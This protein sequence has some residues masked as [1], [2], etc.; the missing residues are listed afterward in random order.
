MRTRLLKRRSIRA[1]ILSKGGA[2]P[3]SL[4]SLFHEMQSDLSSACG[5]R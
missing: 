5:K 1:E 3:V 2:R 4:Y